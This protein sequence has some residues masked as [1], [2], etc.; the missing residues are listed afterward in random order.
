MQKLV[1]FP[2]THNF[3][4]LF[5]VLVDEHT[6]PI[7]LPMRPAATEYVSVGISLHTIS[8]W[9][10]RPVDVN[11]TSVLGAIE[12]SDGPPRSRSVHWFSLGPRTSRRA[13]GRGNFRRAPCPKT[14]A[15]VAISQIADKVALVNFAAG[16]PFRSLSMSLRGIP[17]TRIRV[18]DT[19]PTALGPFTL[20]VFFCIVLCSRVGQCSW[21][22]SGHRC[23]QLSLL[24]IGPELRQNGIRG[25]LSILSHFSPWPRIVIIAI[26]FVR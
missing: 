19:L 21:H 22:R 3:S 16:H 26:R 13:N 18:Q 23:F 11:I 6:L 10:K 20:F 15:T 1:I 7:P 8:M 9:R 14:E 4:S 17:L 25:R 5:G 12:V 24:H 2:D